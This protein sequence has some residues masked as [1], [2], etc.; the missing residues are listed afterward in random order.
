MAIVY[1]CEQLHKCVYRQKSV[2]VETDHKSLEDV[3]QKKITKLHKCLL[4]VKYVSNEKV[5]SCFEVCL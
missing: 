5:L 4:R 1:D 2:E 3:L